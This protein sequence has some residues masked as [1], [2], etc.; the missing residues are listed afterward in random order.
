MSDIQNVTTLGIGSN[1]G[2][3]SFFLLMG[4]DT[5]PLELVTKALTLE[6]RDLSLALTSRDLSLELESRSL[7]LTV[8][9]R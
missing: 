6:S 4:L 2:S 3:L 8:E 5:Y 1:P 9:D 7:S